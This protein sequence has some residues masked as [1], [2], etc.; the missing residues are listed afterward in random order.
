[1]KTN[2]KVE[3]NNLSNSKEDIKMSKK[4]TKLNTNSSVNEQE[5]YTQVYYDSMLK[6]KM[7]AQYSLVNILSSI[8]EF[9]GYDT[10]FLEDDDYVYQLQYLLSETQMIQFFSAYQ[11]KESVQI[12]HQKMVIV[13]KAFLEH[14]EKEIR[15]FNECSEEDKSTFFFMCVMALGIGNYFRRTELINNLLRISVESDKPSKQSR[16]FLLYSNLMTTAL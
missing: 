11:E 4:V 16:A 5:A 1:M 15:I 14:S 2:S 12:M 7:A 9:Y 3:N 8:F 6:N 10:S 13:L